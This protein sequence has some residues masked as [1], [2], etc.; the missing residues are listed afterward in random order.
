MPNN[1]M[2]LVEIELF[3]YRLTSVGSVILFH[4]ATPIKNRPEGLFFTSQIPKEL[5]K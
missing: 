4:E 5:R 1:C 3:D 2:S